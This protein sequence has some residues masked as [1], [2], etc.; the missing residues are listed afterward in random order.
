MID[1]RGTEAEFA[2]VE[3]QSGI[4]AQEWKDLLTLPTPEAQKEAIDDWVALGRMSWAQQ[5]NVGSA[6][7]ASLEV[8]GTIAG[9]VSGVGGA[10][11]AIKAF[12]A[13]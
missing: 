3:E 1:W 2:L 6:V 9:V 12:G 5:A 8:I 13:L 11:N 7:L 10:T 4:G